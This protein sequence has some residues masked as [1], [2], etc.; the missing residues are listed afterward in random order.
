MKN[1]EYTKEN[2]EKKLKD[3]QESGRGSFKSSKAYTTWDWL[4]YKTGKYVFND[5]KEYNSK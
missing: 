1:K 4:D 2:F 3:L 5:N